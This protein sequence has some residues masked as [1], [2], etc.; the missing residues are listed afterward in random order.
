M[1]MSTSDDTINIKVKFNTD[2]NVHIITVKKSQ[3][4]LALKTLLQPKVN[5]P[6]EGQ[7]LVYRGKI[8]KNEMTIGSYN[9]E[10]DTSVI[11][12]KKH[13]YVS[14][15]FNMMPNNNMNMMQGMQNI[16]ANPMY[17]QMVNQMLS[18]PQMMQNMMNMMNGMG[19]PN[20]YQNMYMP[21]QNTQP[22]NPQPVNYKE[23]YKNQLVQLK[24]M[25]FI[26]E[27]ANIEALKKCDGNVQFAIERLISLMQ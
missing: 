15:P 12:I 16:F 20:P 6:P 27:D 13:G 25:G 4:V 23:L 5:L 1:N 10:N 21:P 11:L 14:N 3:T 26:N 8:L 22:Y 19:G 24:D 17:M 9:I 18:N 2:D 7:Q